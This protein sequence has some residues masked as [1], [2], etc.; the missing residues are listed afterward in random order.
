MA[1]SPQQRFADMRCLGRELLELASEPTRVSWS[2]SFAQAA[3]P[4]AEPEPAA[5]LRS[6]V[7]AFP[8]L[9]AQLAAA[10]RDLFGVAPWRDARGFEWTTALA[11]AVGLVSFA[12]AFYLLF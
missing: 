3:A 1:L 6:G 11:L 9:S 5:P 8:P 12:W 2:L 7:P 10:F 4:A